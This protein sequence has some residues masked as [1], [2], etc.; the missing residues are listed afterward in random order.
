LRVSAPI[1]EVVVL[2]RRGFSIVRA[3]A[4]MYS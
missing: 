3:L 1:P 2:T 4:A